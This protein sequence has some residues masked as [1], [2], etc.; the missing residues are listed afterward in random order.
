VQSIEHTGDTTD[1][2]HTLSEG[3]QEIRQFS[4]PG[5]DSDSSE[6]SR[7]DSGC[8]GSSGSSN[9]SDE[10]TDQSSD[11]QSDDQ[12]DEDDAEHNVVDSHADSDV[13]S[14]PSAYE[15]KADG[16]YDADSDWSGTEGGDAP[17]N[18]SEQPG[19]ESADNAHDAVEDYEDD[20]AHD[21]DEAEE[22][23]EEQ[24]AHESPDDADVYE[25]LWIGEDI[26]PYQ[27]FPIAPGRPIGYERQAP[28]RMAPPLR[29]RPNRSEIANGEFVP[30]PS[31]AV[32]YYEYIDAFQC[33]Q[34]DWWLADPLRPRT[35]DITPRYLR[36][37]YAA[38][39]HY[40]PG[41]NG[42]Q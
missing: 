34:R 39:A 20:D 35:Y 7:S 25:E 23:K 1:G 41:P 33:D 22:D 17:D 30:H 18:Q 4:K 40:E 36:F 24:S 2:Y 16:D 9:H 14:I 8:G 37:G 10:E 26:L 19:N 38:A 32:E 31:V 11:D 28:V 6:V 15:D 5:S 27:S 13:D 21:A 3:F 12:S 42:R 29:N